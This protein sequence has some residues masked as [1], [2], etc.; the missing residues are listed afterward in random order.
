M[1]KIP[2][3]QAG[4]YLIPDLTLPCQPEKTLGKYGR[5]RMNYLKEHRSGLY[6][7]M[8]LNGTLIYHLQEIDEAANRRLEQMIPEMKK[9]VGVTENLKADDPMKWTSMM[10]MIKVQVEEI[11]LVELVLKKGYTV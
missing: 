10:N 6:T 1:M 8:L 11:V 9:E 4:D 3:K 2:Y 5:M 7:A